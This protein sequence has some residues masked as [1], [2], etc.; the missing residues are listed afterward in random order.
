MQTDCTL[1][2]CQQIC[3][4]LNTLSGK[5]QCVN[6]KPKPKPFVQQKSVN[7]FIYGLLLH[8]KKDVKNFPIVRHKNHV[9]DEDVNML[10]AHK[11]DEGAG[12]FKEM[13]CFAHTLV[14]ETGK[15]I[16]EWWDGCI[17]LE[18]LQ[19]CCVFQWNPVWVQNL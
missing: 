2:E 15:L 13:L 18:K 12:N 5:M 17:W 6:P 8:K 11:L 3:F 14:G 16:N 9:L 7:H 1:P 10:L 19:N 4:G